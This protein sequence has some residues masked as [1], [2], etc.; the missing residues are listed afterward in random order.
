METTK[1]SSKGQVVIPK[2]YR[3]ALHWEVG[4]E[5]VVT[6]VGDGVLLKPKEAFSETVLDEVAACL[7]YTGKTITLEEMEKAIEKGVKD[8]FHGRG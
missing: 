8:H 6:N 3:N 5:F 1:L 7:P 4:Q 2:N